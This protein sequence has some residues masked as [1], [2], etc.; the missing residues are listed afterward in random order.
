MRFILE[1]VPYVK[2][3]MVAL[4]SWYNFFSRDVRKRAKIREP[5]FLSL[6]LSWP[7]RSS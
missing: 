6:S 2:I 4:F 1:L 7:W 5:L 3:P